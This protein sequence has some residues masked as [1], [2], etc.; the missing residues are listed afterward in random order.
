MTADALHHPPPRRLRLLG[1][2]T[3]I[4]LLVV[5]SIIALLVGILLPALGQARASARDVACKSNLRSLQSLWANHMASGNPVIPKTRYTSF[6]FNWG[7]ALTQVYEN[8]P[9]LYGSQPMSFNTCPQVH[10]VFGAVDYGATSPWGYGIN[11]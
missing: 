9:T 10:H 4:E 7:Q 2:F 5:I 3:L 8:A 1:G 11:I 6:G